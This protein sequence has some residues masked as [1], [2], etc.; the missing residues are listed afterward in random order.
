[1]NYRI[2]FVITSLLAMLFGSFHLADDIVR[3]FEPGKF[4]TING[5]LILVVWLYA[6]LM[7]AEGDWATSSSSSR[8]CSRRLSPSST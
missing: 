4:S 2:T 8:R 7:L 5:I 1:M 3:G 6:T